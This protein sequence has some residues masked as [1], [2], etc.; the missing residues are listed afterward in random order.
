MCEL[1][2]HSEADGLGDVDIMGGMQVL[3]VDINV[4]HCVGAR[5]LPRAGPSDF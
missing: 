5:A 1:T 3:A 2:G 4:V